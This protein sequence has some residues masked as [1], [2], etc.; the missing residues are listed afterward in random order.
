MSDKMNKAIGI[1]VQGSGLLDAFRDAVE[2]Q[3]PFHL[4]INAESSALMPLIIEVVGSEVAVSHTF[5]QM[6]DVMRDPEI[7][8]DGK[9][10]VATE[11]TQDPVGHYER[12]PKGQVNR[13]IEELADAW[14]KNLKPYTFLE[15]ASYES[16]THP[17]LVFHY[18]PNPAPPIK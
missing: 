17:H 2:K 3:E 12:V 6:G 15:G 13:G 11:I 16:L 5:I 1:V 18:N 8:F 10:W 9:T 4:Q 7:V 14:A